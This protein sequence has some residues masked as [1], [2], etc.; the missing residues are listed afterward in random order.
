M[1][2]AL[3]TCSAWNRVTGDLIIGGED[4]IERL[5]DAEGMM[6]VESA[7]CHFAVSSVA[8]LP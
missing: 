8:F 5:F 6:L 4:R 7:A 3:V 1:G 2:T